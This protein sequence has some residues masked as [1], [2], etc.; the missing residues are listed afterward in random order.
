MTRYLSPLRR[1]VG[2]SAAAAAFSAAAVAQI[3]IDPAV[4]YPV[5]QTPSAIAAGDFDGDGDLDLAVTVNGPDR[6]QILTNVGGAAFAPG[7]VTLLP[8]GSGAGELV[9]G[10]FDA[11]TTVDLAVCLQNTGSVMILTNSGAATFTQAGNISSGLNPRAIITADVD[12]DGDLDLAVANRDSNTASVLRN[13]GGS[14]TATSIT[15]GN[16]PRAVAL[17]DFDADQDLDLA[18]SNHGDRNI[19]VFTNTG[20]GAFAPAGTLAVGANLRPEGVVAAD[21][22]GDGRADLVA[23]VNGNGLE[24]VQVH[25]ASAA[26]F[27]AAVNYP[28]GGLTTAWVAAGDLD[29]DGL[30][31]VVSAN[32]DSNN[33]SILRNTGAGVLAAAKL[34]AVG[35]NPERPILANL[36]RDTDLDIAVANRNSND[37]SVARNRSCRI[38]GDLNGDDRVDESDLGILLQAWQSTAAGDIDGDGDTDESDLGLLLANWQRSA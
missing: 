36:D 17:G 3:T 21:L 18:V 31:D 10:R 14:F 9:A 29:C 37:A 33:L 27:N 34:I 1:I 20:G 38:P 19:S 28:S 25:V 12:G 6:V 11:G 5:G 7:G 15:V 2:P 22:T 30:V 13:A 35:L 26:G 16:D 23:A 4:S 8:A 32:Q 24:F